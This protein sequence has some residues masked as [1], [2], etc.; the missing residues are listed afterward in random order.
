MSVENHIREFLKNATISEQ[1]FP[2]FGQNREEESPMQG[3]SEKPQTQELVKGAGSDAAVKAGAATSLAAGSGAMEASPMPQ[4]S[5]VVNPPVEDLGADEPGKVAAAKAGMTPAR[6]MGKGAGQ[7]KTTMP[8]VDP[9]SVVNQPNSAGNVHRESAEVEYVGLENF[10]VEDEEGNEFLSLSED[11]YELLSEED[12]AIVD[13]LMAH[14]EQEVLEEASEE[15]AMYVLTEEEYEQLSDEEKEMF[16]AYELTEEELAEL[17][18]N[19]AEETYTI[20]EEEY[21][22]LSDEEKAQFEVVGE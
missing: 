4:G 5:S 12:K 11:D 22:A 18:Q 10:I 3:S 17:E 1:P 2:G 7:A 13:T 8:G 16:D 20:S 9:V 21:N 19:L 6:P 15:D 14:D